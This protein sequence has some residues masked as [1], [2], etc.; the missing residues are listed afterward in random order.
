MA[1]DE[2][3]FIHKYF[4]NINPELKEMASRDGL[5]LGIGDD[6]AMVHVNAPMAVTTDTLI[7]GVHFFKDVN[8]YI[9]GGRSLEVNFSDVYAMG[10]LPNFV[11][12]SL[13]IP[14][15]LRGDESFWSE[16]ARGLGDTLRAHNA[17]LIGGNIS[18]T[19]NDSAPLTFI[20]TAFG[21]K[22]ENGQILRRDLGKAGDIVFV[23]GDVGT[24]GLYVKAKYAGDVNKLSSEELHE[25]ERFAHFY[26][27][28][29]KHFVKVLAK[30]SECAVDV[31][32]GLLGDLSHILVNSNLKAELNYEALPLS[33]KALDYASKM[34]I[35]HESMIKLALSGGGDYNILFTVSE[36]KK[37]AF[38]AELKATKELTSFR[39]T[40]IGKLLEN[41][42]YECSLCAVKSLD[43]ACNDL[44][45]DSSRIKIVD[46]KGELSPYNLVE[47]SFNHFSSDTDDFIKL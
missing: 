27:P 26:N 28:D 8:P 40:A 32:D 43:E 6:A 30:Y 3:A 1:L 29:M 21:R 20:I 47:A 7:E 35:S 10:S 2:F 19:P 14:V 16:Y 9:L 31:S 25:F 12:L 37:D 24:N 5:L 22:V 17:T 39:V 42:S 45:T 13:I 18:S 23:T 4:A 44:A 41:S 46:S 15:R 11:T 36:A 38:L 34:G 33:F